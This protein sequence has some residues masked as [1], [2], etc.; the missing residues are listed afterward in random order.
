MAVQIRSPRIWITLRQRRPYTVMLYPPAQWTIPAHASLFTGKYANEHRM[1]TLDSHLPDNLDTMAT[2]VQTSGY[3]TAGFSNNPLIGV[4]NNGMRRGFNTFVYYAGM[5]TPFSVR[6]GGREE[7]AKRRHFYRRFLHSL[8][9]RQQSR[10]ILSET[11][12]QL[13]FSE[14]VNQLWQ[15]GLEVRGCHKGDTEQTLTDALHLL[16]D[17][18]Y[19]ELDQPIFT[20]IN[21]MNDHLPYDLPDWAINQYADELR[22][23]WKSR[24][25]VR[26]LNAQIFQSLGHLEDGFP[27]E[28]IR[29]TNALHNAEVAALDKKPGCF[30]DQLRD[31]GRLD[32]TMVILTSDH[33]EQL[34]DKQLPGHGFGVFE[35]L[36]H[37]P[38]V[39]YGP[40]SI[41]SHSTRRTPI[42]STQR[43]FHTVL[44]AAE[45]ATMKQQD[46]SLVQEDGTRPVEEAVFIAAEAAPIARKI[47]DRK[48][49]GLLSKRGYDQSHRADYLNG[50]KLIFSVQKTLFFNNIH[51]DPQEKMGS[52]FEESPEKDRLSSLLANYHGVPG[53]GSTAKNEIADA[54]VRR[55]LQDL[56]YG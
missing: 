8:A 27:E 25:R 23:V 32:K 15:T 41:F 55:R 48:A 43:I 49:P 24:R 52:G 38:P 5:L 19:A 45:A 18:V 36:A 53:Q 4:L 20:F 29:L 26:Q 44:S 30:F 21:L 13:M 46:L 39:I 35:G 16:V 6:R 9:S 12:G 17:R 42:V 11:W 22:H 37:V 47:V 40:D 51:D 1:L 7:A 31:F 33:G 14:T 28:R 54:V 56:V 50:Y 3:Y 10:I 2:L 34:G